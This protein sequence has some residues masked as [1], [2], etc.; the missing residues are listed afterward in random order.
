VGEAC[1]SD[2]LGVQGRVSGILFRYAH[3]RAL[4]ILM[5]LTLGFDYAY[6]QI[7]IQTSG[8]CR[9][10]LAAGRMPVDSVVTLCNIRAP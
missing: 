6:T 5:S 2:Q 10:Y 8:L 1:R 4:V 9:W 7:E 3:M